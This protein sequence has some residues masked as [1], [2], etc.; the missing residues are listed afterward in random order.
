MPEDETAQ[1]FK[2]AGEAFERKT[3][4][5]K[6][7]GE[8]RKGLFP[9]APEQ[10]KKWFNTTSGFICGVFGG[11]LMVAVSAAVVSA[12]AFAAFL[13]IMMFVMDI[14]KTNCVSEYRKET[15]VSNISEDIINQ[16][17]EKVGLGKKGPK[18]TG[19]WRF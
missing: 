2:R 15:G 17:L 7:P 8:P 12:L 10:M 4:V 14:Q 6:T 5:Q 16:C 13:L 3:P 1:S 9:K 11:F 19:Y 18:H